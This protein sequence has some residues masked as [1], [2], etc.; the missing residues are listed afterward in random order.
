MPEDAGK[1]ILEVASKGIYSIYLE[2]IEKGRDIT[3]TDNPDALLELQVIEKRLGY[4]METFRNL[5]PQEQIEPAL[6]ALRQ[7]QDNLNTFQNLHLQHGSLLDYS[8]KMQQQERTM[9]VWLEA[10]EL[11]AAD[12]ERE[13]RKMQEEFSARYNQLAR[14]KMQKR[15]RTLFSP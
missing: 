2:L 6:A 1:P 14:K 4:E 9:P 12:R 11:L 5:Y 10:I 13:E 7:L 8:K 3:G 15:F